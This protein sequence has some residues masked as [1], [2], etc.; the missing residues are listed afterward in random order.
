NAEGGCPRSTPKNLELTDED[1]FQP[2]ALRHL[3]LRESLSP[4][5]TSGFWQIR[6]RALVDLQP[7]ELP[8]ELRAGDR[9]EAVARSR[10]V[11]QPIALVVPKDQGIERLCASRVA[12]DHELLATVHAHLH[13]RA[14]SHAGFVNTRATLG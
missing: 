5:A 13:P 1:G 3:R 7:L 4:A 14:R 11:H 2:H 6:E 8:K 9:R 12:A 10:C